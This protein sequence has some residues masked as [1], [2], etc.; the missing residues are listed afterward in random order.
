VVHLDLKPPNVLLTHQ[1][2]TVKMADFGTTRI[3]PE[4]ENITA[5]SAVGTPEYLPPEVVKGAQHPYV[6]DF[7]IDIFA[8]GVTF[9]DIWADDRFRRFTDEQQQ[10]EFFEDWQAYLQQNPH[11]RRALPAPADIT[12]TRM[13]ELI[14]RCW[15]ADPHRRPLIAEIL[16]D[17]EEWSGAL[18]PEDLWTPDS[19]A[20]EPGPS[21]FL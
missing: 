19:P 14:K 18:Q 21:S 10:Q 6:V 5:T 8:L 11:Y 12:E 9:W 17:L 1:G 13:F 2:Q 3:L 7:S 20:V 15:H 16:A 4:D